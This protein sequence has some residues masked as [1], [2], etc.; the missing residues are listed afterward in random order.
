MSP[1]KGGAGIGGERLE[2]AQQQGRAFGQAA[3]GPL[4]LLQDTMLLFPHASTHVSALM[5]R[6]VALTGIRAQGGTSGVVKPQ[7]FG[8]GIGKRVFWKRAFFRKV[9][10]LEIL[11]RKRFYRVTRL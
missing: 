3:R 11:R 9:H 8:F 5:N 4:L 7:T 6:E 10:L 2:A 1:C